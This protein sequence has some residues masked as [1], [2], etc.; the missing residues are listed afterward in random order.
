MQRSDEMKS[1]YEIAMSRL[2]KTAPAT[3]LSAA[4]KQE[5]AGLD[6]RY[7]AKVAEREIA[8]DGEIA[9]AANDIDKQEAL[10]AQ[11]VAERKKLQTELEEKKER[12]RNAGKH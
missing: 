12:V 10:R 4:Q 5:L 1:A 2:E 7:A 11:L 3:K 9:R 8:L 6:S